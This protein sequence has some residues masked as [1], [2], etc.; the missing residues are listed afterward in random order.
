MSADHDDYATEPVPG[1][2]A[3]LPPG[4]HILWQGAPL[5]WRL[6]FDV[7]HLRAVALYLA[8][9]IA[10]RA[11]LH[12]HAGAPV[13]AVLLS[14]LGLVVPAA[15]VLG[16][17]A[18]LGVMAARSTLYTITNRRV[19]LRAGVALTLSINLPFTVIAAAALH[20]RRDGTGDIPLTLAAGQRVAYAH[21][22]PHARP[23]RLA[24]PAPMLRGIADAAG[25]ARTLGAA[26]Q[27]AIPGG[28]FQAVAA[29]ERPARGGIAGVA[30]FN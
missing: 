29:P 26:M 24:A 14:A 12:L 19:V 10:W 27:A 30:A 6:A 9:L 17:L 15:A 18:G 4:E 7:F 28:V 2:P 16:L 21:L 3:A 1:L 20:A 23:W 8:V 25:V 13:G 11:E 5:W 22:W